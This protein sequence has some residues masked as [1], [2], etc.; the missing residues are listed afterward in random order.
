MEEINRILNEEITPTLEKLRG[1][2][3]HYIQWTTNNQ[4]LE[5]LQRFVQAWDYHRAK[6]ALEKCAEVK[7][8]AAGVAES[9]AQAEDIARRVKQINAEIADLSKQKEKVRCEER[10]TPGSVLTRVL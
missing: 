8:L 2:R 3:V 7:E 6:E 9:R 10:F 5:K 1:E 4:E